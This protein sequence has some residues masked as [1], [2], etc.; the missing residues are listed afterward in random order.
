MHI[1]EARLLTKGW[2]I[3]EIKHA[4]GILERAP[5]RH[6]ALDYFSYWLVLAMGIGLNV[7]AALF[8]MPVLLILPPFALYLVLVVLGGAFGTAFTM[9]YRMLEHHTHHKHMFAITV[10]PTVAALTFIAVAGTMTTHPELL[11]NP[12]LI[13]AIYSMAF[14]IPHLIGGKP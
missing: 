3:E 8:L 1:D 7:A 10:V 14:L 9:L 11:K 12:L 13:G 5:K 2:T 4:K 6:V